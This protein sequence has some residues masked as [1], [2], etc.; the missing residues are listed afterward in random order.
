MARA[1]VAVKDGLGKEQKLCGFIGSR[2]Y[3]FGLCFALNPERKRGIPT[4]EKNRF[5]WRGP[6]TLSC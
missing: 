3:L 2:L 1:A 6:Q 4:N 5:L